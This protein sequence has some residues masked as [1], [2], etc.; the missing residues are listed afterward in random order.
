MLRRMEYPQ[1]ARLKGIRGKVVVQF[2]VDERGCARQPVVIESVDPLLDAE[3][4]RLVRTTRFEP[5][6]K[7][8]AAVAVEAK[9]PFT[10]GGR[11]KDF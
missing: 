5:A 9:L 4:L 7:S 2:V 3:A 1:E 6:K 8:G 10:F 11:S